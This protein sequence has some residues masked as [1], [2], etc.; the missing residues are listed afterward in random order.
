[1]PNAPYVGV[2]LLIAAL[3]NIQFLIDASCHSPSS[4]EHAM[5]SLSPQTLANDL[6]LPHL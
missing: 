1:M 5:P 4:T 2:R 6:L 3:E